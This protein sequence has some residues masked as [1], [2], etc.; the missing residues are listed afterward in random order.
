MAMNNNELL[1]FAQ[2]YCEERNLRL[3]C[4]FHFGAKL[5]GTDTPNSD[6]DLKGLFLPNKED[7]LLGELPKFPAYSTGNDNSRNSAE[8]L[9]LECWSLHKFLKMV[10]KGETG[11]LDLLFA[12][13]NEDAMLYMDPVMEPLF[14][15]PLRLFNPLN[16]K[17]YVGYAMGQANKYSVK[18]TRLHVLKDVHDYVMEMPESTFDEEADFRLDVYLDE[19]VEMFGDGEFCTLKMTE[20]PNKS[21][22]R[23]LQ[24]LGKVHHDNTT[25]RTFR[26]R[27]KKAYEAYGKRAH[28]AMEAD[29]KDWKA[30]SHAVRSLYQMEEL[31]LTGKFEFPLKH[32]ETVLQV[33]TGK[34]EWEKVETLVYEGLQRV[35]SLLDRAKAGEKLPGTGEYDEQFVRKFVLSMYE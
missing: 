15:K 7:L 29:G 13:S 25:M 28:K 8:D 14:E 35:E 26:E 11:A 32:R 20:G 6:D 19:F 17:A 22:V 9:D 27:L 24:L 33:K 16:A 18:G 30:L 1:Q 4:L 21:E 3:L 34:M 12:P 31:L 10:R 2:E 23:S 5:Y